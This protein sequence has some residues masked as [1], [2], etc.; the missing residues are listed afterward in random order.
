MG[1]HG[2]PSFSSPTPG[3]W[4][5]RRNWPSSPVAHKSEGQ[6][7]S[8]PCTWLEWDIRWGHWVI[9]GKA[10]HLVTNLRTEWRAEE[11]FW[12]YGAS[13]LPW[14]HTASQGCPREVCL[15]GTPPC[16]PSSATASGMPGASTGQFLG[17]ILRI[18]KDNLCFTRLTKKVRYSFLV[19]C[20]EVR[21]LPLIAS[22]CFSEL[23]IIKKALS[24]S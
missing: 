1:K 2:T 17:Q 18:I 22:T 13:E 14:A 10:Q 9:C 16:T 19:R 4:A 6:T 8:L 20:D 7:W 21:Q 11:G 12:P 5:G 24:S 3:P 23:I 15:W